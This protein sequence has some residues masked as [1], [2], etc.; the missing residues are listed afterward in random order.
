MSRE[1]DSVALAGADDRARRPSHSTAVGQARVAKR[2]WIVSELYY[3]EETSTGHFM[4]RLAE[5]IAGCRRPVG[6]LCSQPTY[7]ARGAQ[8]PW[9]KSVTLCESSAAAQRPLTKTGSPPGCST[10]SRSPFRSSPKLS[11]WFDAMTWLWWLRIPRSCLLQWP[12]SAACAEPV[13]CCASTICIRK[14]LRRLGS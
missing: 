1:K 7:S 11:E 6:V 10:P 8:A 9:R 13:A 3:P 12:R 2:A 14:Y 5:G 4:T